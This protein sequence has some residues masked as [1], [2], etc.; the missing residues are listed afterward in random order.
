M[1]ELSLARDIVE[2]ASAAASGSDAKRVVTVRVRIGILA[3]VSSESL[4][5]HFEEAARNTLLA[6]ARL[7]VTAAPVVVRCP[8]CGRDTEL[9]DVKRFVCVVCGTPT[10][11]VVSGRELEVE[12][13][14][15]S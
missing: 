11:E 4:A 5:F 14:E 2:I 8:A 13:I 6:G 12:S 15:I 3:A 1:H 10:G 7:T 9:P